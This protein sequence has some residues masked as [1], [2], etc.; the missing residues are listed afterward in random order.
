MIY[1][2]ATYFQGYHFK[3]IADYHEHRRLQGIRR[4]NQSAISAMVRAIP[5]QRNFRLASV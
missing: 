3:H 5:P 1:S 4:R 2:E